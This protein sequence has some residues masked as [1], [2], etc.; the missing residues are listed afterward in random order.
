MLNK[1]AVHCAN[2][3]VGDTAS[4][5]FVR[6][7]CST[8]IQFRNEKVNYIVSKSME[9][10]TRSLY[11]GLPYSSIKTIRAVYSRE[12]LATV[13]HVPKKYQ[14]CAAAGQEGTWIR[15]PSVYENATKRHQNDCIWSKP[16]NRF[17]QPRG[18]RIFQPTLVFPETFRALGQPPERSLPVFVRYESIYTSW[19]N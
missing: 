9:T 11:S 3:N 4:V 12:F 14:Q 16:A 1:S 7:L 8:N 15:W 18:A 2:Q 13:H 19:V 17:S 6:S 5:T 10:N